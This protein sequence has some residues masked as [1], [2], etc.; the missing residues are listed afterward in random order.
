MFKSTTRMRSFFKQPP[1]M[2]LEAEP[3]DDS[4]SGE[5]KQ[6]NAFCI[7]LSSNFSTTHQD[8]KFIAKNSYVVSMNSFHF[9]HDNQ[10]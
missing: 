9:I 3:K 5:H 4:T 1:L 2:H 6:S 10:F 8:H 7:S